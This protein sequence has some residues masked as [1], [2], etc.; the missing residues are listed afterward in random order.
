[1]PSH[2]DNNAYAV[3]WCAGVG[4]L[5]WVCLCGCGCACAGVGVRVL[6]QCE[7]AQHVY[8]IMCV[9]VNVLYI[10]LWFTYLII[11]YIFRHIG[12]TYACVCP[13]QVLHT[14]PT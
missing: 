10:K 7:C 3:Y 8:V 1:M 12:Q 11:S 5:V 6:C 2:T 9:C 13:I 14:P 4:V